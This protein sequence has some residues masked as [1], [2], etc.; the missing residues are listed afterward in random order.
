MTLDDDLR[1]KIRKRREKGFSVREIGKFFNVPKSTVHD[2][3]NTRF[4]VPRKQGRRKILNE[5]DYE[6]IKSTIKTLNGN[7]ILVTPKMMVG[8]LN[9]KASISTLQR[10]FKHLGII[11]PRNYQEKCSKIV[12]KKMAT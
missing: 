6:I 12:K 8:I 2:T 11:T 1:E 4:N 3:I 10:A 5:E 7:G 9:K